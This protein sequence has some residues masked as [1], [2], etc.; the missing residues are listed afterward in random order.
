MSMVGQRLKLSSNSDL[1]VPLKGLEIQD[2]LTDGTAQVKVD[3]YCAC[4]N[5][6]GLLVP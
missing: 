4:A 2:K 6:D 3:E 5:R 1:Y